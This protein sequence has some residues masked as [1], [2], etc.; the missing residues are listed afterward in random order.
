MESRAHAAEQRAAPDIIPSLE[1]SD[2]FLTVTLI[3]LDRRSFAK[4][5]PQTYL[6]YDPIAAPPSDDGPPRFSQVI[7][8]GDRT[9]SH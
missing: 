7:F 9:E 8:Q 2:L 1:S 4:L 3:F 5:A 6:G